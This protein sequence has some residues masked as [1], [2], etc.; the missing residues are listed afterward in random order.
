MVR[1]IRDVLESQIKKLDG[2]ANDLLPELRDKARTKYKTMLQQKVAQLDVMVSRG[3]TEA[4]VEL[5]RLNAVFSKQVE[6]LERVEL[7]PDSLRVI[8]TGE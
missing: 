3:S 4:A 2:L 5:E 6:A 1:M 8:V 7:V